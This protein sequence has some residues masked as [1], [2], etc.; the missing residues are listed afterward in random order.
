MVHAYMGSLRVIGALQ[1]IA[2][3]AKDPALP[4]GSTAGTRAPQ[5]MPGCLYSYVMGYFKYIYSSPCVKPPNLRVKASGFPG[6]LSRVNVVIKG[7]F[8][9]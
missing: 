4:R 2:L 1:P 8:V 7:S 3:A 6:L 5:Y 9:I